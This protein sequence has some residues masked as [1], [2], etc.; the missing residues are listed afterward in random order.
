MPDSFHD[1]WDSEQL[2]PR[3]ENLSLGRPLYFV[4]AVDSTNLFLRALPPDKARHG[5]LALAD[6]QEA[7][8]GRF[9]RRWADRPGQSLLFSVLL[10]AAQPPLL[11]PLLTLG[12][13]VSVCRI[14]E[15]EGIAE[16]RI[17]WPNDVVIGD[18]KVCGILTERAAAPRALVLGVGLNVHQTT[19]DFPPAL[20][21]TA[22]SLRIALDRPWK[23]AD[24]LVAF[25]ADFETVYRQWHDGQDATI[26]AECRR[27][28]STLGRPVYLHS[29]GRRVEGVAMDLDRDGSLV[30]REPTGIV[31]RRHSGDVEEIRWDE[32]SR[33]KPA[34]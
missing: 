29:H 2:R 34:P 22:G 6:H 16:P 13:A 23:R 32:G 17:R 7:G 24:L 9:D 8:R 19:E 31:S 28:M 27:R 5:T 30:L 11:W 4:A 14:L 3:L 12:A 1:P 15:R 25:L 10:E 18:R 26:L 33:L 20:R 21:E